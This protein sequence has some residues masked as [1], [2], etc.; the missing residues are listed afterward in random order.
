RPGSGRYCLTTTGW[1]SHAESLGARALGMASVLDH[2]AAGRRTFPARLGAALHV[3]VIGKLLTGGRA[4]VAD[5]GAAL[6]SPDGRRA[7]AAGDL[8]GGGADIAAV[9][10]AAQGPQVL[11]V[12]ARNKVG[13][14]V[15]TRL[16]LAHA[17]SARLGALLEV[18][19]GVGL[20]GGL[21]L[22]A[23]AADDQ[24]DDG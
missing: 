9:G 1:T 13:A 8:G 2:L 14:M 23:D 5:L 18:A 19:L 15:G 16:A 10:A 20:A 22:G 12:A 21:V 11:L 6:T 4:Q 7:V 17:V 24:P 3:I